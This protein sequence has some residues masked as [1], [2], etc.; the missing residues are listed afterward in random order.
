MVEVMVCVQVYDE[1]RGD[2]ISNERRTINRNLHS[3]LEVH[4]IWNFAPDYDVTPSRPGKYKFRGYAHKGL[5]ESV[6][7]GVC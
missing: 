5:H 7:V 6:Y 2:F 1:G 3:I 4:Y